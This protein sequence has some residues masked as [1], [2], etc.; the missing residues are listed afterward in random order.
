MALLYGD[1]SSVRPA[2]EGHA[3][4]VE[5]LTRER[6]LRAPRASG[7]RPAELTAVV[8]GDVEA[9]RVV[10]V[11]RRGLRRLA[12]PIAAPIPLPQP[13]AAPS[14]RRRVVDPDDEQG[15]GRHRVRLHDHRAVRSGVLRVTG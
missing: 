11:R 2:G 1:R 14:T 15:A 4:D 12:A 6:L 7:S 13:A 5:A 8:V 9:S 3:R 10:D